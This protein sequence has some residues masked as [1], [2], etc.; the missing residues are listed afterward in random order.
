MCNKV[1]QGR[2]KRGG[3]EGG[4]DGWMEQKSPLETKGRKQNVYPPYS[5]LT[6]GFCD[7]GGYKLYQTL[8]FSQAIGYIWGDILAQR[9]IEE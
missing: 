3:R 6:K 1:S 4:T 9:A 2:K 8:I 5:Y 7:Q